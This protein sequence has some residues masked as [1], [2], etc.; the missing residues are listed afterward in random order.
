MRCVCVCVC[1]SRQ[2]VR[3]QWAGST[4]RG[5]SDKVS[6]NA[7]CL[8]KLH[9]CDCALPDCNDLGVRVQRVRNNYTI[10]SNV[11]VV[12]CSGT[13]TSKNRQQ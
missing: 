3:S 6:A 2:A 4:Q 10:V 7:I 1:A 11:A 9:A 13:Q 5:R 12:Q 8:F